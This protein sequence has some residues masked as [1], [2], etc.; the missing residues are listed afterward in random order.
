VKCYH[1]WTYQTKSGTHGH[2]EVSNPYQKNQAHELIK[3]TRLQSDATPSSGSYKRRDTWHR[4]HGPHWPILRPS[5]ACVIE[6][7]QQLAVLFPGLQ[8]IS[9]L[10]LDV[11]HR[12]CCLQVPVSWE[13]ALL[14]EPVLGLELHCFDTAVSQQL[15]VCV[16]VDV[17]WMFSLTTCSDSADVSA[18]CSC[19]SLFSLS[20]LNPA[21][22]L[23]FA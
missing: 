19:K 23:T 13:P 3:H 2:N 6:D 16:G 7:R 9:I 21:T 22:S 12:N 1:L 20:S 18:L 10:L 15:R 14:L 4:E 11:T 17:M 8:L 5:S